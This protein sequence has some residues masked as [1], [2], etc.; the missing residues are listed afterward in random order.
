MLQ[1]QSKFVTTIIDS[2][3]YH[4]FFLFSNYKNFLPIVITKRLLLKLLNDIMALD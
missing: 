2:V 4:Q 3:C 1:L